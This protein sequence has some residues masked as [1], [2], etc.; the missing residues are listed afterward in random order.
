LS[1]GNA[2]RKLPENYYYYLSKPYFTTSFDPIL[3]LL[4]RIIIQ[5]V[6]EDIPGTTSATYNFAAV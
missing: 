2:R 6:W 3:I 4:P 5:R 1:P